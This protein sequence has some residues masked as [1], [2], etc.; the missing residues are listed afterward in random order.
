MK[1]ATWKS[2]CTDMGG[3]VNGSNCEVKTG[4]STQTYGKDSLV[5][6]GKCNEN[7]NY[8]RG[9]SSDDHGPTS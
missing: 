3:V 1:S 7:P 9:S 5:T 2:C 8:G 6:D 4:D